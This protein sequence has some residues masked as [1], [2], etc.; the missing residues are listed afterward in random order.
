M[1]RLPWHAAHWD[2]ITRARTSDR[3]GHAL[4]LAGPAGVG[5]RLFASQLARTLLCENSEDAPCET[6]RSCHLSAAGQHPNLSWLKRELNDRGDRERRD[7]TLEQVR[8]MIE[9]ISL[10]GH[11]GGAKV[12]VLDPVDAL[13]LG[14]INALLKT[15][16]EPPQGT[17]ILMISERPMALLA[18][19]RSRCQRFDFGIPRRAD[20]LRWL[21]EQVPDTD[22]SAVLEACGGAPLAVLADLES[23]VAQMR[24]SWQSDLAQ[25]TQ[26]RRDPIA[27]AAQVPRDAVALWLDSLLG[28]LRLCLRAEADGSQAAAVAG[29]AGRLDPVRLEPLIVEAFE[30]RKRL[31]TNPNPQLL[32]ESLMIAWWHR[33][34]PATPNAHSRTAR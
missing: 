32:V 1:T 25:V 7:I 11:Y 34:R 29:L 21:E 2:R 6:C 15:V 27:A 33:T 24:A 13:N 22:L 14:G 4:L 18:T 10:H 16:E 12:V 19:L 3:L 20:A 17:F 30:A 31:N 5:K 9:R 28:L 8:G 23:G 26:G